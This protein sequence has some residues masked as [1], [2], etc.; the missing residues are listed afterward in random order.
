MDA[1]ANDGALTWFVLRLFEKEFAKEFANESR[2]MPIGFARLLLPE[3]C[4][5]AG[6]G[7][8]ER[9]FLRSIACGIAP[10][11]HHR[12]QA[13]WS[14]LTKS[15]I[16]YWTELLRCSMCNIDVVSAS[17][18]VEQ[19]EDYIICEYQAQRVTVIYN[20]RPLNTF[21]SLREFVPHLNS[22]QSAP[23][24]DRQW[25]GVG[26]RWTQ[27]REVVPAGSHPVTSSQRFPMS[28]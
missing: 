17:L 7:D 27:C 26:V 2:D 11:R 22:S 4:G 9:R 12:G 1:R 25:E 13:S 8:C 16:L 5:A 24:A 20:R 28:C 10:C 6:L 14:K 3:V 19:Y 15:W 21:T 23:F 18:R